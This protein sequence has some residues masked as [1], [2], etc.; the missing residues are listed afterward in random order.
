MLHLVYDSDHGIPK[1]ELIRESLDWL[2]HYLA[3]FVDLTYGDSRHKFSDADLR[4]MRMEMPK[5]SFFPV[6]TVG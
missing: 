2:D 1:K 4:M 3:Q 5:S 6:R